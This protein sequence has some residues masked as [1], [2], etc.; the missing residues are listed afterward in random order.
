MPQTRTLRIVTFLILF[1]TFNFISAQVGV[2]TTSPD[3]SSALD[4]T[5]SN[6]G[7]LIPRLTTTQRDAIA[8]PANG[9]LVYNTTT[10][11]LSQ[12]IGTPASPDW[13]CISGNIV[14]FFYLPSINIDVSATGTGKTVNLY[15][16]YVDQFSS[17]VV[18]SPGAGGIPYFTSATDLEYYV[19][20]Y[21]TDVLAN[22][23]LS[24]AGVLTYDVID[25]AS[26]CSFINVVLVVK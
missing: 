5:S 16:E 8:S 14:R 11:C 21:D 20:A 17:P 1:T 12:N 15:Q 18:S 2:G 4:V 7:V 6:T 24:A 22:L 9:L 3:T 25:N 23:S 10:N 19:T 26:D 13:V